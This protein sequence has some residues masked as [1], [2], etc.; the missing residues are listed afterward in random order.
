MMR[1]VI[2]ARYSSDNQ[3]ESSIEDQ[4]RVAKQRIA[5]EGWSL[6]QV[7]RDAAL[8]GAST[9]RPGYQALLAAA[10]E[11]EFDVVV[12]EALDRLSRDQEDVA[13]LHKRLRFAGIRI[14]TLAEGEISELQ[15][16]FK[17]TMNALFLKDL[18]EKT[19][20]GMR[21]R[22]AAGKSASGL[23]FGYKAVRA[24]DARGEPTR[25][26][27]V[28]VE[29]EALVVNRIFRM[30]AEGQ[31]PI[32]IAKALN[33]EGLKG[34]EGRAWRDTTIR[35]HAA[36]GTGVLRNELYIGRLVWNRMKFIKNPATGKRVS[37]MNPRDAW[38]I[39]Q[40]PHLRI[41]EDDLWERVQA[42]LAV[43]REAA[44][45]NHPD[46]P[47][48]WENRRAPHILTGKVFCASC[49]GA[50]ASVGKDYLACNAARKQGVCDNIT[51]VRRSTL[52]SLVID[53]LR[54]NLMQPDDV[55][56]FISAFTMEWNRLSAEAGAQQAHDAAMLNSIQ[57]KIDRII[58]AIADGIRTSDMK[59][60]L[61]VL[62]A[63]KAALEVRVTNAKAPVPALHPNLAEVYRT[64]LEALEQALHSG[65]DNMAVLERLRDL[66]ERVEIGPGAD[67][68]QPEI[69]L[70]GAIASMVSLGL[71]GGE[72]GVSGLRQNSISP[73]GT[74]IIGA[75]AGLFACSVKVVAG[76]RFE[77]MTFRL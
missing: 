43:M 57:R 54:T 16:G 24:L 62:A 19:H 32:A 28:I 3:S 1:A 10:R 17:G 66:V 35:G 73:G 53:A 46:R 68:K 26:E 34:P 64:R 55:E 65:K 60:K 40:V 31:S 23:S 13:A 42:R 6:V 44:G 25:G 70:T 7:Y 29:R 36:R 11:G 74:G 39:E 5:A 47:R 72:A 67:A 63:Q 30:F 52:E 45:A 22:V 9:L 48:F 58:D 56:E 51:G 18:A 33:A 49:G 8:S 75:D 12:A 20:R 77:L 14:V 41:I 50:L 69:V 38:V 15:I 71:C 27:R 61:E 59:E 2:Y 76:T 4:V 21:G 37:R